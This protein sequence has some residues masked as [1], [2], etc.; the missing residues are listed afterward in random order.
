MIYIEKWPWTSE[1]GQEYPWWK[2]VNRPVPNIKEYE[3]LKDRLK[4]AEAC[5][6]CHHAAD[7]SIQY[8]DNQIDNVTINGVTEGFENITNFEISSGR[9]FSPFELKSGR[10]YAVIGYNIAQKLFPNTDPLG[11]I[12]VVRKTKLKSHR[13]SEQRREK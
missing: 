12:I 8:Q 1:E 10:K 7:A 6:F 9:Y 5:Q 2:Y 3:E 11:K 13:H 4:N